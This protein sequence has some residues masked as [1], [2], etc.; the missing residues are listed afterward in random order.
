MISGSKNLIH[1]KYRPDIDGLR[2]FSVF[3]VIGYHAFPE[4]FKAGF[5]GVDIFFVISGFLI[6]S[7]IISNL[8]NKS[9][10]F[11]DFY[12]RRIKRIFPA[13][14]LI[15]SVCFVFGWFALF[16]I[17]FKQLGKHIAG[18]AGFIAN[19]ILWDE[20][21]Y[22]DNTA[23][24]KPLLH[25]WSLGIE[26]QFYLFWPLILWFIFRIRI[27][28]FWSLI[29]LIL[30][31]FSF[32]I[33]VSK[34]DSVASFYSPLT[35]C[36]ELLTGSFLALIIINQE[37][38]IFYKLNSNF[39]SIFGFLLIFLAFFLISDGSSFSGL[40]ALLPVVGSFFIILAG[41]KALINRIVLSNK[42]LVWFGLISFP[43]YL[44][45]WPLIS[46][47]TIVES[48]FPNINYRA[49]SIIISIFLSWI[50]YKFLE[51]PIRSNKLKII[52]IILIFL[53]VSIGFI[54][55]YSFSKN[56][57]PN[58]SYVSKFNEENYKM[59]FLFKEDDPAK[60]KQCMD[61]YGLKGFI[62]YCNSTSSEK[63]KI[64]LIGDS[65]A[66]ALY[67]G[68]SYMLKKNDH[69]LLNL[70]GRLFLD[71]ET[72]P[73]GDNKEIEVYKGGIKATQYVID[74]PYIKTIIMSSKGHYLTDKRWIFNLISNPK[75]K[76]KNEV[77]KIAMR[78]TLDKALQKKK[79]I[80]F[81]ID[82]PTL[83]FDP[84]LCLNG[85]PFSKNTSIKR[86][87]AIPRSSHEKER[88]I[89]KELVLSILKDYPEVKVIDASD[90]L[91]DKE[92]CYGMKNG[93]ILYR[94]T[95]HLSLEGG[96]L[97]SKEIIKLLDLK[98]D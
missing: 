71:V 63:A 77:W 28:F 5:I 73:I 89:Y 55:F 98:K 97:I 13:L 24:T 17:E 25:I 7:I 3:F 15:L 95:D 40:L 61:T 54:G 74:D 58:R 2:A 20:A 6:S 27:N 14:I 91:C 78:N 87:C 52:P 30:I 11:L 39:L 66:R 83:G 90:I 19:Y 45:H 70:G 64:A 72:Y 93:K 21:G 18:S 37:K 32:N 62:R 9:F 81:I 12:I 23:N 4:V 53:M 67:D 16:P 36:W 41:N 47:A 26:E 85:R 1:L 68:L 75:I 60:H 8:E 69:N 50:T 44:W 56:G 51:T 10:Y 92:N 88:K 46:F 84:K 43:L 76:N 31:S 94:D 48:H 86:L 34:Y 57:I 65:H 38:N 22:F 96:K 59:A 29:F 49:I 79:N 35:R 42:I 33:F 82:N 80:I